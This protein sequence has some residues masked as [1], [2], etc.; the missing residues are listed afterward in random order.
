M[1]MVQIVDK[2]VRLWSKERLVIDLHI[3]KFWMTTHTARLPIYEAQ[4]HIC[5]K[6]YKINTKN[7]FIYFL[8]LRK[9]NSKQLSI[10]L[11]APKRI[12][13]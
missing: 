12:W 5:N 10:T 11:Q 1:K 3:A 2:R 4:D 13:R 8:M 6:W 9:Y 7:V